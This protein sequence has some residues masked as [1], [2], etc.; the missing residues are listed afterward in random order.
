MSL[1]AGQLPLGAPA[2]RSEEGELLSDPAVLEQQVR[3]MLADPRAES[4]GSRFAHQWLRLQDV[5][6][7]W[8]DAFLYPNFSEQLADAMVE[9]TELFFNN[10]VCE[11]RSLL[12]PFSADYTFLNERLAALRNRRR[13]GTSH[14]RPTG[15]R[16]PSLYG[17]SADDMEVAAH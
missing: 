8:P 14:L 15:G 4:L 13:L 16:V 3:R 2:D 6:K 1:Q 9:E 17:P 5:G 11:D 7:V 10:L 12:E